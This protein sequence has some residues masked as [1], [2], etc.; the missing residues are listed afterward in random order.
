MATNRYQ[1]TSLEN[2][3][4][5]LLELRIGVAQ[6]SVLGPLLFLI[7]INDLVWS[8]SLTSVLFADDTTVTDKGDCPIVL[9][10]RFKRRL[11][12]LLEW[13]KNNQL[14]INW[15]KTKFMFVYNS[16]SSYANSLVNIK[17]VQIM[18][19][20]VEVV[21]KFKL[22]G[23]FVDSRLQFK[24]QLIELKKRVNKRL[25]SIKKVFYLSLNVKTQF[26][27]TFILPHFDYCLALVIY[28]TK[29]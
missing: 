24:E 11:E 3:I 17:N 25:Y 22:L 21:T 18:G 6:G 28:F 1:V 15:G 27:K 29:T 10:D 8:S 5:E 7:F 16:A 2:K 9:I 20:D 23:V 12:P 14:T 26:F 4:S 19:F 13:V